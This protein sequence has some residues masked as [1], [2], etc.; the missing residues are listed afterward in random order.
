MAG[1]EYEIIPNA[2]L[3]V[4]YTYRNLVQRIEDMSNTDGATYF[5]G[6]PGQGI[7]STFPKAQRTYNAVTV[8]FTKNFADLWLA[9]ASYTWAKLE[10]NLD[11]LFRPQDGQLDPNINST[12][13]LKSL[14]LNQYGP[15]SGDITHSLKLFL[16]KEFVV[17]PVFSWSLGGSFNANSGTPIDALG[18]HPLYGDRQAFIVNRGSAGR[19]PWVTSLDL[20]VNLSYRFTKDIGAHRRSGGLQHLQLPAA[21]HRRRP[22]HHLQRGSDRRS[23]RR[24]HPDGPPGLRGGGQHHRD[25]RSDLRPARRRSPTSQPEQWSRHP[26]ARCRCPPSTRTETRSGSSYPEDAPQWA[27]RPFPST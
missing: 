1:A 15:L 26:T 18:A 10:G 27:R 23:E 14:L 21:D 25:A 2:R 11:G 8:Q 19:L 4:T 22:V 13:D 6:N 17:T 5:I 3:G 24:Q 16:A 20:K 12:F 7:A 9:Q